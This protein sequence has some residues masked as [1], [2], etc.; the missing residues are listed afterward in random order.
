MLPGFLRRFHRLSTHEAD[1]A[2]ALSERSTYGYDVV[3]VNEIT[4][5]Q[6]GWR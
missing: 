3:D 6:S 2:K 1:F 4:T 5:V